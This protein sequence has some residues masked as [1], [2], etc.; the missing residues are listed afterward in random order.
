MTDSTD[1]K[2][3]YVVKPYKGNGYTYAITLQPFPDSTGR[4]KYKRIYWG[5]LDSDLKFHPNKSYVMASPEEREKLIFPK[6]WDITENEVLTNDSE[7]NFHDFSHKKDK[8][9]STT[10][11][12]NKGNATTEASNS[13]IN[14]NTQSNKNNVNM[15]NQYLFSEDEAGNVVLS[16]SISS[17]EMLLVKH[18]DGLKL[19][20]S[21]NSQSFSLL[22][23]KIRPDLRSNSADDAQYHLP[24]SGALSRVSG[25]FPAVALRRAV[26]PLKSLG[27]PLETILFFTTYNQK[28]LNN[29]PAE[30]QQKAL[31]ALA[32]LGALT[33]LNNAEGK[34]KEKKTKDFPLY[35]PFSK[36]KINKRKRS[37]ERTF[38]KI[39]SGG[40]APAPPYKG[41]NSFEPEKNGAIAKVEEEAVGVEKNEK[42]DINQQG[43]QSQ[44]SSVKQSSNLQD[45][46]PE[47]LEIDEQLSDSATSESMQGNF[48]QDKFTEGEPA[49]D[50]LVE[51]IEEVP[52]LSKTAQNL[53]ALSN[54]LDE[55]A[56]QNDES[57]GEDG[58]DEEEFVELSKAEIFERCLQN[59]YT[60]YQKNF[61]EEE[62]GEDNDDDDEKA[63]KKKDPWDVCKSRP[64]INPYGEK[65]LYQEWEVKRIIQEP[66][67][68]AD[69]Q[70]KLIYYNIWQGIYDFYYNSIVSE[71]E[72]DEHGNVI[73]D[74]EPPQLLDARRALIPQDIFDHII[75]NACEE[76]KGQ[77]SL[78]Y[79]ET[80]DRKVKLNISKFYGNFAYKYLL[81][82]WERTYVRGE[83]TKRVQASFNGFRIIDQPDIPTKSTAHSMTANQ[84]RADNQKDRKM[85]S[86]IDH[87]NEDDLTPIEKAVKSFRTAF[88]NFSDNYLL[89]GFLDG[90]GEA[91]VCNLL[92]GWKIVPW[93]I[94]LKEF[95][96]E[97]EDFY[98]VFKIRDMEYKHGM[99]ISGS[100]VDTVFS[101]T[102]IMRW[103][104]MH[105]YQSKITEDVLKA[106]HTM[107]DDLSEEDYQKWFT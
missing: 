33:L 74:P 44:P 75:V 29:E 9:A 37:K 1:T 34:R 8:K 73:E 10:S 19:N 45:K 50:E 59:I 24:T 69:S 47:V 53:P 101:H 55:H 77:I 18:L 41:G 28:N 93:S 72:V 104:E 42:N 36:K 83:E 105:G 58:D 20:F 6:E 85:L 15:Q 82:D 86:A 43:I 12:S 102:A 65:P 71:S 16:L 103:N 76:T 78:G 70:W 92:P 56:V 54:K 48:T 64:W 90:K 30:I 67:Y 89:D 25:A 14:N 99:D 60:S 79:L 100:L 88:L 31:L 39:I 80:E 17:L 22:T 40:A 91:M 35:T 52:A 2:A 96:V 97:R 66:E 46:Q 63:P 51:D 57:E 95:G 26:K 3:S 23:A 61:E 32:E 81:Y 87:I 106:Q 62:K 11:R 94:E 49:K 21:D 84:M 98:K 38:S 4:K 5:F 27:F 68:C 7:L 107:E 13:F